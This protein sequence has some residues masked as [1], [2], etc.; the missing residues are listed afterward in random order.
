[1][2][3]PL[4]LISAHLLCILSIVLFVYNFAYLKI[5]EYKEFIIETIFNS[6]YF[7]SDWLKDT[8]IM[9]KKKTIA[10]KEKK[11]PQDEK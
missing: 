7:C 3:K 8:T 10:K 11:E 1:M 2:V 6:K 5:S 9:L 4:S